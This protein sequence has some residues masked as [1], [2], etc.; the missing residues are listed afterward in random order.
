[1]RTD[2]EQQPQVHAQRPD[3]CAGLARHPEDAQVALIVELDQLALVDRPDTQLALDG[4]DQGRAL[5][6][7]ARQR[8]EGL[9]EG[10]LATGD[11]V[12]EPDDA[13]VFLA[14]ALLGLDEPCGA[15]N[16]D[17]WRCRVSFRS[18]SRA[19]DGWISIDTGSR[20]QTAGNLGIEGTGV[21]GLLHTAITTR[22]RRTSHLLVSGT[23]TYRRMR[24]SQATTSCDE[25]LDGLS[26]LI[27]P[28]EMYD[29]MSRLK[30]DEPLGIGVKWPDRTSILS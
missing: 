23:P 11:G 15:V 21:A 14:R 20:T 1:M 4:R 18:S 6:Q 28:L 2:T 13:D 29:L 3:V 19:R 30:G 22:Q 5:E 8:L 25:G 27:T 24:F 10:G 26:R 7:R 16:A 12:V 9:G 17:N